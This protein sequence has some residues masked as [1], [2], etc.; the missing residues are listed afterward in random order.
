MLHLEPPIAVAPPLAPHPRRTLHRSV[1]LAIGRHSV[2]R[3]MCHGC[4]SFDVS[5]W[6]V[7]RCVMV[8]VVV[9]IG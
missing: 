7:V 6:C 9:V 3:S 1:A 8:V 5:W 4:V 2:C